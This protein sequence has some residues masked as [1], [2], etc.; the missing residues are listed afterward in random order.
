MAQRILTA[1]ALAAALSAPAWAQT[2]A[3][4]APAAAKPAAAPA[5]AQLVAAQSEVAFTSRQMGVPVD[6]RFRRFEAQVQFDPKKPETARIA[7]KVD[8]ASITMGAPESEAEVVKPEW[9]NT[10]KFPQATFTSTAVKALGGNRFE[11]AGQFGLKGI[12]RDI[13]VPVTLAAAGA[14]TVATGSFTLKRLEH[15]IGEGE[16][17]DTSMVANDVAVKFKLTFSGIAPL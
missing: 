16:W 11:V 12:T 8:L 2:P 3:K 17:A 14:N 10:A 13:V 9:F 7:L 15:R 6:G 5:P 1:L 4:P